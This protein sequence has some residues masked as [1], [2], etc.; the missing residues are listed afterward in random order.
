VIKLVAK[1]TWIKHAV[2]DDIRVEFP[3]DRNG[4]VVHVFEQGNVPIRDVK[5][6]NLQ[7]GQGTQVGLLIRLEAAY[8]NFYGTY[9]YS[10][11]ATDFSS[12]EQAIVIGANVFC[13][14][15]DIGGFIYYNQNITDIITDSGNFTVINGYGHEA[16]G[17]ANPPNYTHWAI[18]DIVENTDD[19]TVWIK[20]TETTMTKIAG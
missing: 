2:I 14:R 3:T 13:T 11:S 4:T 9:I 19:N 1:D 8:T 15:I 6:S 17:G 16:A 10:L 20:R 12:D 18:G 5:I 7:M